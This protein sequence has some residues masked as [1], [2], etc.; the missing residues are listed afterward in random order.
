MDTEI[1]LF[2]LTSCDSCRKARR[3]LEQH[4]IPYT[5]VDIRKDTPDTPTLAAWCDA[6]GWENFLNRRSTTWR[7]LDEETRA[8]CGRDTAVALAAAHPALIKRPVLVRGSDVVVG[9]SEDRYA[10]ILGR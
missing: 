9:F 10:S 5:F 8:G 4:S 2:G 7:S 1:S 3:W 6:L